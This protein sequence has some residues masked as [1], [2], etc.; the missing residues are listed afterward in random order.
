[1]LN[2]EN[3]TKTLTSNNL[4]FGF[5]IIIVIGGFSKYIINQINTPK[6]ISQNYDEVLRLT[7]NQINKTLPQQID[8]NFQLVTT[9]PGNN[10]LT[11]L[12]ES[13]NITINDVD[14]SQFNTGMKLQLINGYK[15]NPNMED[16]RKHDVILIY[17]YRDKMGNIF[18]TL[19]VSTKDF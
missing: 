16:F 13:P 18:A 19:T 3:P 9:L 1:M 15:T 5:I 14:L 10:S 12:F 8:K 7:S 6:A 2:T 4:I 17:Q 11:Y